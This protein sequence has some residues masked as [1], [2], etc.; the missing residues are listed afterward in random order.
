MT[1]KWWSHQG[2]VGDMGNMKIAVMTIWKHRGKGH[3]DCGDWCPAHSGDVDR[4]NSSLGYPGS[5]RWQ[6]F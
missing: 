2:N 3:N 4:A 1:R 6:H 5:V